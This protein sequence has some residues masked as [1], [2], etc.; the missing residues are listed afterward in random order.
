[1]IM[2]IVVAIITEM[3]AAKHIIIA[4]SLLSIAV[5]I[6]TIMIMNIITMSTPMLPWRN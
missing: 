1:M 3:K 5:I 6:T 2:R 4:K